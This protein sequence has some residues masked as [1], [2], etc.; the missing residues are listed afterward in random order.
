VPETLVIQEH[1]DFTL[2]DEVQYVRAETFMEEVKATDH[3]SWDANWAHVKLQF[4]R[5]S[6]YRDQIIP[7]ITQNGIRTPV[8][9]PRP[10]TR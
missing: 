1:L 5:G 3:V 8:V 6:Y 9:V 7:D 2:Y 4:E 10:P